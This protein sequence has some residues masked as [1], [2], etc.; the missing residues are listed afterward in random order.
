MKDDFW[1]LYLLGG[2]LIGGFMLGFMVGWWV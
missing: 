1:F 2:C